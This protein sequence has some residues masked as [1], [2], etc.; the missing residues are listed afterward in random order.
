MPYLSGTLRPQGQL[1]SNYTLLSNA[2]VPN[3]VAMVSGQRPN[4]STEAN[5]TTY[6]EFPGGAAPDKQGF[7]AGSG[8]VYPALALSLADQLGSAGFSWHAYMEDM[9]NGEPSQNCVHPD[10]GAVDDSQ[11]P[12]PGNEYA[13]RHN[14]FVYF[15]SLLDLGDCATDD[16]PLTQLSGDLGKAKSTASYSFISP[17]LCHSGS[18]APCP[19]GEP[20]GAASADAFLSQWV[21]Q[22]LASPAYKKDGLLVITFGEADPADPATPTPKVG[23]LLM[24]RYLKKNSTSGA[25][26]DPNSLLRS[27]EDLFGLQPLAAAASAPSFAKPLLGHH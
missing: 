27:T 26:Y 3:Y 5:C 23:T 6:S 24:S 14:P 19:S 11:L 18:E 15:H 2:G 20:G 7:V 9:G 17:N 21:P 1:L 12:R 8:C 16:G 13:A 25:A 10:S 4:P 22:I